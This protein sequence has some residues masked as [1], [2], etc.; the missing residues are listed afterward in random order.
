MNS[1]YIS[2]ILI[3]QLIRGFDEEEKKDNLEIKFYLTQLRTA[4]NDPA[5]EGINFESYLIE[6]LAQNS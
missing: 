1:E 3:K 2:N 5:E 6:Y 4:L